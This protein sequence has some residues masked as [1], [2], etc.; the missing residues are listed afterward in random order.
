MVAKMQ[1]RTDEDI[2]D[3]VL[4]ELEGAPKITSKD[5]AV[6]VKDGVVTLEGQVE[7]QYQKALAE[8]AVKK[9]KGVVD[10]VN[11]IEVKPRVSPTDIKSKIEEALRR[12]AELDAR[13]ISVDIDGGT[14]RLYGSVRAWAEREEAER[15]AWSAPIARLCASTF[16]AFRPC[17]F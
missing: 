14:V 11:N 9:L 16:A 1:V 2:R 10:V 5:I 3:G 6:A 4:L 17:W 13:R 8:S 7:W 12:S 15:A